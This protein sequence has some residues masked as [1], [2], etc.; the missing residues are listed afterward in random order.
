[1]NSRE[2]QISILRVKRLQA[3]KLNRR[4]EMAR[5]DALLQPLVLEELNCETVAEEMER[6]LAILAGDL[7]A[8]T[9]VY[10]E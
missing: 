3:E 6:D 5:I 1:M 9:E 2:L 8:A 7:D 4:K 10:R